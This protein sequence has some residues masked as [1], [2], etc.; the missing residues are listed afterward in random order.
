M[1]PAICTARSPRRLCA[2]SVRTHSPTRGPIR[3]MTRTC[4]QRPAGPCSRG[5]RP[6]VPWLQR[7]AH[8]GTRAAYARVRE[9]PCGGAQRHEES[10]ATPTR[11][12]R[13]AALPSVAG[14]RRLGLGLRMTEGA[15][16]RPASTRSTRR[17]RRGADAPTS[18]RASGG[19]R[20]VPVAAA[21]QRV[22]RKRSEAGLEFSDSSSTFYTAP[23]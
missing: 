13:S 14:G 7:P 18:A 4:S 1:C 20:A 16:L 11:I 2:R 6:V 15:R 3:R 9:A 12:R 22:R 17:S 23:D 19:R 8:P 5:T 10:R 21:A